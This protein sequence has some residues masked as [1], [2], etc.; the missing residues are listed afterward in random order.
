MLPWISA[1]AATY[2]IPRLADRKGN[3]RLLAGLTLLVAGVASAMCASHL[4]AVA[5]LA[6][7]CA[8]SGFIAAQP[9]FWTLPMGYLADLAAA[10]GLGLINAAGNLGGFVAPNAKVW[11][12][13]QFASPHAG[14]Y[15][16]AVASMLS[17]VLMLQG[18][19]AKPLIQFC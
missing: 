8:A 17:G 4:S 18:R 12:D 6:L 5:L 10:G 2:W 19:Y 13:Q 11:A 3:H 15:L 9:L 16:L 7:C 1:L 14:L